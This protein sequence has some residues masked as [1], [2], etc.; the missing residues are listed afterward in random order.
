[1]RPWKYPQPQLIQPH[2]AQELLK[3][4]ERLALAKGE[5]PTK[6]PKPTK[7][8]EKPPHNDKTKSKQPQKTKKQLVGPEAEKYNALGAEIASQAQ[9]IKEMKQAQRSDTEIAQAN[10]RYSHNERSAP[11]T[12]CRLQTLKAELLA[13]KQHINLA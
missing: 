4:K 1:M 2:A 10:Q 11:H 5:D 12:V 6:K 13:L 3:A 8:T 9:S 7:K